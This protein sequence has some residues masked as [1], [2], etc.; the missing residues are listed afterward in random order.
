[1][2]DVAE[3]LKMESVRAEFVDV[4]TRMDGTGSRLTTTIQ[5]PTSQ[6]FY[7]GKL[8]DSYLSRVRLGRVML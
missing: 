3:F 5:L 7:V 2:I 1:M 4:L 6:K 8:A